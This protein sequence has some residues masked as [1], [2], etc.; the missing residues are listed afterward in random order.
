MRKRVHDSKYRP[1]LRRQREGK[2][3]YTKRLNLLRGDMPRIVVRRSLKQI[4]VSIIQYE[5]DGDKTI[6]H[7]MSKELAKYG[8]SPSFD[9]TPAAYLTG[10]LLGHKVNGKIKDGGVLDI[11]FNSP[12]SSVVFAALSGAVDSGISIPHSEKVIPKKSRVEGGSIG[13]KAEFEEVLNK[14]NKE[15][16][17]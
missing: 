14:I 7:A 11:G 5:P 12:H 10:Y 3:N 17:I 15:Y 6:A 1:K 2:T 13:K 9:S 4:T 8:W 16:K